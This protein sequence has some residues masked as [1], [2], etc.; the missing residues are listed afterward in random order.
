[1]FST[2]WTSKHPLQVESLLD[3]IT[4]FTNG[5]MALVAELGPATM[6][7]SWPT[8]ATGDVPD[9]GALILVRNFQKRSLKLTCNKT[10]S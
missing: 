6:K 2:N 10:C 4:P 7:R 8:S 1:M 5:A 9:T 3:P